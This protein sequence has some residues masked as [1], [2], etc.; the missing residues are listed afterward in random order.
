MQRGQIDMAEQKIE[1]ATEKFLKVVNE[2][3]A[4]ALPPNRVLH[5]AQEALGF[6]F[7]K[8]GNSY[9]ERLDE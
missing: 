7:S 9:L 5:K 1:D 3:S 2:I 6:C 8:T 4:V